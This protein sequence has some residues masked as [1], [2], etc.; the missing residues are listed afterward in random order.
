MVQ[1]NQHLR[2]YGLYCGAPMSPRVHNLCHV[3]SRDTMLRYSLIFLSNVIN[4][5]RVVCLSA[6]RRHTPAYPEKKR[7]SYVI[8]IEFGW[9]GLK[10]SEIVNLE[11]RKF[12]EAIASHPYL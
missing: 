12:L 7:Q 5:P 11:N 8:L 9:N 1:L 6:C 2:H 4:V 3:D 10:V